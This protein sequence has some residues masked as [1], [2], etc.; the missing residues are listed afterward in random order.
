M[1]H[2]AL[3]RQFR[4][5]DFDEVVEQSH[6]VTTLRQS[7]ISGQIGHAYLF[8]GTRGTGK[9]TL[10]KIF[11]RGINCLDP[12]DGN[13][14]NVCDI[15]KGI[16]DSSILDVIEI[17]AA[18]NNSVENIRRICDEVV[19]LPSRCEY[20]VY[21]IDEV[22][23]LSNGAFNALLKTLEEPPQHAVFLLATTEPHRIPATILSR[24]QRYDLRR[25]SSDSIVSRL[26]KIADEQKIQITTEALQAISNLSDGALRDAISLLDQAGTTAQGEI[27]RDDILKIT[28][29]VDDDFILQMASAILTGDASE[30]IGH[31]RQLMAD[32]RDIPYFTINLARM[33]RDLLVLSVCSNHTEL[34][35]ASG[36][37]ISTMKKLTELTTA[38]ELI[39]IISKISSLSSDLKWT[40]DVKTTFEIA[41]LSLCTGKTNVAHSQPKKKATGKE[42]LIPQ[43]EEPAVPLTEAKPVINTDT[44]VD[45]DSSAADSDTDTIVPAEYTPHL[46]E[47]VPPPIF[48]EVS[49]IPPALDSVP[50]ETD[51]I[52]TSVNTENISDLSAETS[53]DNMPPPPIPPFDELLKPAGQAFST[54]SV[55]RPTDNLIQQVL[56]NEPD[57]SILSAPELHEERSGEAVTEFSEIPLE[58][59]EETITESHE[60]PL[61]PSFEEAVIESSEIPLEPFEET[62]IESSENPPGQ[63]EMNLQSHIPQPETGNT[64]ASKVI[65]PFVDI[66]EK[67]EKEDDADLPIEENL[68]QTGIPLAESWRSLL[69]HWQD[70]L[71]IIYLQFQKA[72]VYEKGDNLQLVF[73]NAMKEYVRTLPTT[74]DYKTVSKDIIAKLPHI[75]RV[76]LYTD[77]SFRKNETGS[78]KKADGVSPKQVQWVKDMMSFAADADIPVETSEKL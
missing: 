45:S 50:L 62:A 30:I 40:P 27:S 23:M 68:N 56:S 39:E 67:K 66:S 58:S 24:C 36:A 47:L 16:I 43:I 70:S 5:L 53:N 31:T 55:V 3:Y 33:F 28:G 26:R 2:L 73:P 12:K 10:A 54:D 75:T 14:C 17:D 72:T 59:F 61:E 44:P 41:L 9:T 57:Q 42:K 34:V 19:F 60:I 6:A 76:A 48:E 77:S 20:K 49:H 11:A 7:I 38:Q 22:H 21:I 1:G 32:G 71:F 18:S 35:Q 25:I 15:C 51:S 46:E 37:S 65:L 8:C 74:E 29:I 64:N 78:E 63:V 13:P 4:P 69:E 52:P